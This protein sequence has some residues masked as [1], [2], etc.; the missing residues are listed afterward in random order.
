LGVGQASTDIVLLHAGI[1]DIQ[2]RELDVR[3]YLA[4]VMEELRDPAKRRTKSEEKQAN[5]SEDTSLDV[6]EEDYVPAK[7]NGM[8]VLVGGGDEDSGT[9]P[10]AQ[11]EVILKEI[12]AFRERSIRRDRNKTWLDDEV[13][14]T[15]EREES[16]VQNDP[17]RR[18]RNR[19]ST[20]D[21]RGKPTPEIPSGPAA[22]RRRPR[23][24]GQSIKYR[25]G[26]DRYERDDE[27]DTPDEEL[28]R[29]RLEKKRK[30]LE[31]S[32]VDVPPFSIYTLLTLSREKE[33]GCQERKCGHLPS[34][35]R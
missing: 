18:D 5:K 7:G 22:D 13:K 26:S 17:R 34:N 19:E 31:A 23:D 21:R 27:D 30:D 4:R 12:A 32:F 25:S 2:D 20:D 14:K 24:Y 35:A 9:M 6:D 11:R 28:E 16:P 3:A 33:N 1:A 8:T 15:T 29:R 10:L